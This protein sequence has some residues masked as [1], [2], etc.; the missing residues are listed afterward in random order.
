MEEDITIVPPIHHPARTVT[1]QENLMQM[2]WKLP[3]LPLANETFGFFHHFLSYRARDVPDLHAHNYFLMADSVFAFEGV[4]FDRIPYRPPT[5]LIDDSASLAEIPL[6]PSIGTD[7]TPH[8]PLTVTMVRQAMA[9][10]VP[11]T[12]TIPPKVGP[13]SKAPEFGMLSATNPHVSPLLRVLPETIDLPQPPVVLRDP[14][15]CAV[16]APPEVVRGRSVLIQV[17]AFLVGQAADAARLAT[18][19]DPDATRRG[20]TSLTARI[21]REQAIRFQL[22]LPFPVDPGTAEQVW[23]GETTS[24]QFEATVPKNHPAGDTIGTVL[25]SI[26]DVPVGQV[27][28]KLS[29]TTARN[30]KKSPETVLATDHQPNRFRQ[31]FVSYSSKD[32]EIVE[33]SVG[34]LALAEIDYF[35]DVRDL[36]PGEPWRSQLESAIDTCDLFLLFWSSN[37]R[38]SQEVGREIARAVSRLGPQGEPPPVIW[39]YVIEGPPEPPPPAELA[40]LHFGHFRYYRP[41]PAP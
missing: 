9:G 5:Q 7:L 25:I 33:R 10:E 16:F 3:S 14:V 35:Q 23:Q 34:L 15:Q 39:P 24:V 2:P 12:S 1:S 29:I 31:A 40:R 27:K 30:R 22:R 13:R 28:F 36:K 18:E 32:R 20:L 41:R 37:A 38:E 17:F 19:F 6:M 4:F 11:L 26:D 8:P 21:A